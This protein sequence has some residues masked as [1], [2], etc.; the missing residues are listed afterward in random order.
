MSIPL[1][2]RLLPS[3]YSFHS[4][5]YYYLFIHF[6]SEI[7]P[8]VAVTS[9]RGGTPFRFLL[10]KQ[11]GVFGHG[12]RELLQ[13]NQV[14][15]IEVAVCMQTLELP[16]GQL[17]PEVQSLSQYHPRTHHSYENTEPPVVAPEPW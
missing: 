10:L 8:L 16:V 13:S 14:V 15:V 7:S 2:V 4:S 1:F 12:G 5:S 6:R 17:E 3:F 9:L 11:L